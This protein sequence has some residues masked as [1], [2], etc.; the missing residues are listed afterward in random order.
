MGD[1]QGQAMRVIDSDTKT[2]FLDQRA[3]AIN[4]IAFVARP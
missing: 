2:D 3:P 1:R 4:G